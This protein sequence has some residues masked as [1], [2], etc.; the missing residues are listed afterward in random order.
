MGGWH[1][2][3][4][5]TLCAPPLPCTQRRCWW[6]RQTRHRSGTHGSQ[7]PGHTG[8]P[9]VCVHNIEGGG[10]GTRASV[11]IHGHV[12]G[13]QT[14]RGLLAKGHGKT[15]Q[16]VVRIIAAQVSE[17]VCVCV[18]RPHIHTHSLRV[19]HEGLV[20]QG[21]QQRT[22]QRAVT[23][24]PHQPSAPTPTSIT[25]GAPY[26]RKSPSPPT[27]VCACTG[28]CAGTFSCCTRER[29]GGGGGLHTAA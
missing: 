4:V 23:C 16:A 8:Q 14:G 2:Q 1:G 18:W 15:A 28:Q 6:P 17:R 12:Q 21:A 22:N 9:W 13:G 29:G 5:K 19:G 10:R 7:A 3:T 26:T 27:P 24:H 25:Q 20:S 11:P